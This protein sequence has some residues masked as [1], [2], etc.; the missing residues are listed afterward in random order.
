MFFEKE[1]YEVFSKEN[2]GLNDSVIRQ[3]RKDVQDKLLEL[4][5]DI[6]TDYV[7]NQYAIY[8][9]WKDDHITSS[10]FPNQTNEHTVPWLGLRYGK[11]KSEIE[12]LNFG[13]GRNDSGKV[14]FQKFNNFEICVY[15]NCLSIGL[16]HSTR[17]G[18]IDRQKVKDYIKNDNKE[19]LA[20]LETA[21][22]NIQGYGYIFK[23]FYSKYTSHSEEAAC[24]E[25]HFDYVKSD[26]LLEEFLKFYMKYS[27]DGEYDRYDLGD[28]KGFANT[29]MYDYPIKDKRIQ[30]K[31]GII[32]E[33]F[34]HV[35]NLLE[36]YRVLN[37]RN[38]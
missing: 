23:A 31:K 8:P 37:W 17:C 27:K 5:H 19:F 20:K 10:I 38:N 4:H 14:G 1:D 7:F 2:K 32:A 12:S 21:L 3:R 22:K 33:F 28:S 36:L 6:I 16:Y 29:I 25:F 35:D 24:E 34:Y 13:L 9:H 30:T 15:D 18:G 26:N 11:S